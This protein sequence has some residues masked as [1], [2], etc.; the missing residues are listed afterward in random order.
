MSSQ[1]VPLLEKVL[2]GS[3][4]TEEESA[5][6]LRGMAAGELPPPLAGG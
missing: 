4:L 5:S 1:A 3:D 6:I 2:E